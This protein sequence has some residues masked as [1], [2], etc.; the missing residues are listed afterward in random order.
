MLWSL[1]LQPA[2]NVFL[3]RS[4][5]EIISVNWR[6]N[7]IFFADN[8][9]KKSMNPSLSTSPAHQKVPKDKHT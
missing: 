6:L 5:L 9:L 1:L 4:S 2:K 7:L 3:D 8:F